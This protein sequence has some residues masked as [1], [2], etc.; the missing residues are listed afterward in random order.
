M[1]SNVLDEHLK[2][3]IHTAYAHYRVHSISHSLTIIV[4][5]D[6][7]SLVCAID[8]GLVGLHICLSSIRSRRSY[9]SN[10]KLVQFAVIQKWS[11]N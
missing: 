9:L 3:V 6:R 1:E 4:S 10:L 7:F 5:F 11:V 8:F 2:G